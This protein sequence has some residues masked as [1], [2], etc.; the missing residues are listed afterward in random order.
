M[1]YEF[2]DLNT[3]QLVKPYTDNM[4]SVLFKKGDSFKI[5]KEKIFINMDYVYYPD[6][7]V[8]YSYINTL[9]ENEVELVTENK[10]YIQNLYDYLINTVG[11]NYFIKNFLNSENINLLDLLFSKI[12]KIFT[13]LTKK[14][15]IMT[16][17][18]IIN[19]S[20][21]VTKKLHLKDIKEWEE[22]SNELKDEMK[23]KYY[24]KYTLISNKNIKKYIDADAHGIPEYSTTS[25]IVKI[26][27]LDNPDILLDIMKI[28]KEYPVDNTVPLLYTIDYQGINQEPIIKVYSEFP[29]EKIIKWLNR[30]SD[31]NFIL[32]NP[33]GVS[34]KIL[35]NTNE[36][37]N[38]SI[39]RDD[40]R[41]TINLAWDKSRKIKLNEIYKIKNSIEPFVTNIKNIFKNND[42]G[43]KKFHIRCSNISFIINKIVEISKIKKIINNYKNYYTL[44]SYSNDNIKYKYKIDDKNYSINIRYGTREIIKS[45]DKKSTNVYHKN[46]CIVNVLGVKSADQIEKIIDNVINIFIKTE[47]YTSIKLINKPK[48]DLIVKKKIKIKNIREEGIDINPRKCQRER[49]PNLIENTKSSNISTIKY[50]NRTFICSSKEYAYPGFTNNNTLCCFKKNQKDK[51]AYK[52]NL[53]I[54]N[55]I[56]IDNDITILKRNIILKDKILNSNKLGIIYPD[57]LNEIFPKTYYRLGSIHGNNSILNCINFLTMKGD[58]FNTISKFL[59]EKVFRSLNDGELY[60]QTNMKEYS[61]FLN[62]SKKKDIEN[63][64]DLLSR[65]YKLDIFWF[66]INKKIN[67]DSIQNTPN[68]NFVVLIKNGDFYEG[69]VNVLSRTKLD[70]VFSKDSVLYSVLNKIQNMTNEITYNKKDVLPLSLNQIMDKFPENKIIAQNINSF[71]K[72]VYLS[73][74]KFGLIPILP[75]GPSDKIPE[76]SFVKNNFLDAQIQLELLKKSNIY[77]LKPVSQIVDTNNNTVG[78]ITA[79]G[80]VV[81]VKPSKKINLSISTETMYYDI[82]TLIKNSELNKDIRYIYTTEILYYKELY[83]RLRYTL[84][85]LMNVTLYNEIKGIITSVD[86]RQNKIKQMGILLN[87]I[88]LPR[89]IT[90]GNTKTILGILPTKRILCSISIDKKDDLFCKDNKLYMEIHTYNTLLNKLIVELLQ[91][92]RGAKEIMLGKVRDEFVD[93]NNYIRRSHEKILTNIKDIN[94]FFNYT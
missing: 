34:F 86:D 9:I 78:I 44:Q 82:D 66:D 24:E 47:A 7:L 11:A 45:K 54:F 91:N 3:R 75:S 84:S 59:N 90:K 42:I 35:T 20:T 39:S 12:K 74:S 10:I 26:N 58:T 16:I 71:N 53:D 18:K 15:L 17:Y 32:K 49:Q 87:I 72:V 76:F 93:Q 19:G 69:I 4:G 63:V 29:K 62:T 94:V 46:V 37:N 8:F 80:I 55:K 22:K 81:P 27:L 40:N 5:L 70:R 60:N 23:K 30:S 67:I 21:L 85:K 31:D 65:Y 2:Y 33:K 77:Y 14:N 36:Y 25:A 41:L 83:E 57:I 68:K 50:K 56:I 64:G 43:I 51:D 89:E 48:S 73:T 13:S 52:R 38:G 6:T 88:L 1:S 28:I 79:C 92:T 61:Q